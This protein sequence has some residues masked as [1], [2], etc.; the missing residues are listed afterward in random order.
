MAKEVRFAQLVASSGKPETFA[1][2]SDPKKNPAFM[3]AVKGNRVL[4]LVQEP[5]SKRKDF[6]QIGFHPQPFATYLI[7]P[8]RLLAEPGAR[9]IGLKYEMIE[10]PAV[11]PAQRAAIKAPETKLKQIKKA[12][13]KTFEVTVERTAIAEVT[14]TVSAQNK[15]SAEKQAL[16]EVARQE[17]R[18]GQI[19]NRV[20]TVKAV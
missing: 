10:E 18:A 2:W 12:R 4:T 13:E 17:F 5:T 1:L 19:K 7:F 9:V 8:K 20:K 15:T 3:K 6:G 14:L 11:A 16:A